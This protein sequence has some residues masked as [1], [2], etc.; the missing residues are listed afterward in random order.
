ML[1]PNH[2]RNMRAQHPDGCAEVILLADGFHVGKFSHEDVPRG[3]LAS[4]TVRNRPRPK[5]STGIFVLS[6]HRLDRNPV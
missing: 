5:F 2:A 3:L 1:G 6:L 4:L